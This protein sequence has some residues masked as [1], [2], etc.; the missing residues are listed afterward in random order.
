MMCCFPFFVWGLWGGG[1][2]CGMRLFGDGRPDK[3]WKRSVLSGGR[4]VFFAVVQINRRIF[5]FY[6]SGEKNI[7]LVGA[8]K[9]WNF[10]FLS[11]GWENY[12]CV[13]VI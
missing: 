11:G 5:S 12:F 4:E 3:K 13:G 1:E 2:L 6:R 10:D 8:D 9:C 7:S